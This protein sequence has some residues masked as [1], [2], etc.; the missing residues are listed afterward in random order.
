MDDAQR[1]MPRTNRSRV[2]ASKI[3]TRQTS[4]CTIGPALSAAGP[5]PAMG[6]SAVP[7]E[8]GPRLPYPALKRWANLHR[9]LRGLSR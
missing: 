1:D 4:S 9:P 7:P 2:N 6:A 3:L 5:K 8:L